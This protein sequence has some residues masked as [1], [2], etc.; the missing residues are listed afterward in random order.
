MALSAVIDRVKVSSIELNGYG[1][2][3][4]AS[5]PDRVWEFLEYASSQSIDLVYLFV[6]SEVVAIEC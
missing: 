4:S 3:V 1:V 6:V 5:F 2:A